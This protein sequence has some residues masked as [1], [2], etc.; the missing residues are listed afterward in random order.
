MEKDVLYVA[1]KQVE[2]IIVT[3]ISMNVKY[4]GSVRTCTEQ[5]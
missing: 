2:L 4:F 1:Q 5:K 3:S